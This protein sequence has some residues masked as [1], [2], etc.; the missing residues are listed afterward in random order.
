M[1]I[2]LFF[3]YKNILRP[4]H[5]TDHQLEAQYSID[6]TVFLREIR[7]S[8]KSSTHIA[9]RHYH[10]PFTINASEVPLELV[11]HSTEKFIGRTVIS[12]CKLNNLP[13]AKLQC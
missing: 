1:H 4:Y 9:L 10:D 6:D 8:Y 12:R 7:N 13:Q 5:I 2:E 11:K 3:C